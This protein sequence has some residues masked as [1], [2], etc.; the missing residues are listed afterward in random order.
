MIIKTYFE[1]K[2]F[3]EKVHK[4]FI[5]FMSLKKRA[6][7]LI[8]LKKVYNVNIELCQIYLTMMSCRRNISIFEKITFDL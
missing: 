4:C 5:P 2:S 1:Q 3:K 6:F 8:C 7:R